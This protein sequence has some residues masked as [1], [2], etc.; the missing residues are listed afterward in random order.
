MIDFM[1]KH[2]RD[3]LKKEMTEDYM[4][5]SSGDPIQRS[6]STAFGYMVAILENGQAMSQQIRDVED[7]VCIWKSLNEELERGL[8]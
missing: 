5:S 3:T 1:K 2:V 7:V 8:I 6:R 4:Y